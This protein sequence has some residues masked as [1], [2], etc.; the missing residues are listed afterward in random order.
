MHGKVAPYTYLLL[1]IL[2]NKDKILLQKPSPLTKHDFQCAV[3][4][5]VKF[6]DVCNMTFYG[7]NAHR[8]NIKYAYYSLYNE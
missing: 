7:F 8:I 4:F 3:N 2:I 6:M 5:P 1:L